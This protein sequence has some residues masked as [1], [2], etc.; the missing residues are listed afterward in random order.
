LGNVIL[1]NKT[2]GMMDLYDVKDVNDVRVIL[3]PEGMPGCERE[4]SE[5][6]LAHPLVNKFMTAGPPA[7]LDSRPVQPIVVVPKPVVESPP[8]VAKEPVD[9]GVKGTTDPKTSRK[10]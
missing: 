5:S 4:C 7:W 3:Y 8:T 6:V 10:K 1:V 2:R 9:A